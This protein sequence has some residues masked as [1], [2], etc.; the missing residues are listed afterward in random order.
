MS[1]PPTPAVRDLVGSVLRLSPRGGP[2][3]LSPSLFALSPHLALSAK[4]NHNEAGKDGTGVPPRPLGTRR[5]DGWLPGAPR[6]PPKQTH[7]AS[8]QEHGVGTPGL[9]DTHLSRAPKLGGAWPGLSGDSALRY[10]SRGA[11]VPS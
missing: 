8:K 9:K 1:P 5:G 4:C 11:G 7:L 2:L 10:L 6:H 3:L